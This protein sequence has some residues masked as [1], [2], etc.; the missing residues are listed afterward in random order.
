MVLIGILG[1]GFEVK[2][3]KLPKV[4][5]LVR[6]ISSILGAFFIAISLDVIPVFKPIHD[7]SEERK[8]NGMKNEIREIDF[9][10]QKLEEELTNAPRPPGP[11]HELQYRRRE[12]AER[13]EEIENVQAVLRA[14]VE[15]LRLH[16]SG[17][18]EAKRRI[19]QMEGEQIPDLEVERRAVREQVQELQDMILNARKRIELEGRVEDLREQKQSLQEGIDRLTRQIQPTSHVSG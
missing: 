2:E 7:S 3:L 12:R 8:I 16:A 15:R 5:W 10:I 9:Q 1:G 4:G 14:E 11:L 6:L 18:S 17:D 13:L 19:E